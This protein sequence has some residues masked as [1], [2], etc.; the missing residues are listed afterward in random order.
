MSDYSALMELSD[1]AP[2]A[3]R[4]WRV[5]VGNGFIRFPEPFNAKA[6]RESAAVRPDLANQVRRTAS[7]YTLQ[8]GGKMLTPSKWGSGHG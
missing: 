5:P 2:V 4:H 6:V 1:E 8:V 3:V 7:G